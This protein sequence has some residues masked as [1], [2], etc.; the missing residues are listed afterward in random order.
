MKKYNDKELQDFLVSF[1]YRDIE[2]Q[3]EMF[4]CA[5]RMDSTLFPIHFS[6]KKGMIYEES[7]YIA[8]FVDNK[9]NQTILFEWLQEQGADIDDLEDMTHGLITTFEKPQAYKYYITKDNWTEDDYPKN[10]C[11][12]VEILKEKMPI[13]FSIQ[14]GFAIVSFN[15]KLTND[16]EWKYRLIRAHKFEIYK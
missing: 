12:G 5:K 14:D 15:R 10:G 1:S 3:V 16:E 7:T 2:R 11:L 4:D 6:N 13:E 8:E 9:K